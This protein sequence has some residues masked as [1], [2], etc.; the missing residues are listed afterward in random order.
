LYIPICIQ[1]LLLQPDINADSNAIVNDTAQIS[2]IDKQLSPFTVLNVGTSTITMEPVALQTP[3]ELPLN[4]ALV[5]S[6]IS[7]VAASNARRPLYR[8]QTSPHSHSGHFAMDDD[9]LPYNNS[10]SS[11]SPLVVTN[12]TE[13][14]HQQHSR[15]HHNASASD[16][17]DKGSSTITNDNSSLLPRKNVSAVDTGNRTSNVA[18]FDRESDKLLPRQQQQ[19][20]DTT[21]AGNCS[22]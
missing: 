5:S 8:R 22:S 20:D 2:T 12:I 15:K 18:Q 17:L 9:T 14:Q 1:A 19:D 11:I 10:N 21:S 4:I 16:V 3:L 7:P 6:S 13:Q